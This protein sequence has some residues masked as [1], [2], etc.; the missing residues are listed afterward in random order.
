MVTMNDYGKVC[1]HGPWDIHIRPPTFLPSDFYVMFQVKILHSSFEV[2]D[3]PYLYSA[4]PF[5][6]E[7][8]LLCDTQWAGILK[9]R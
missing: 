1:I 2:C 8:Q 3:S 5:T 7:T 6:G 4:Y 9:V